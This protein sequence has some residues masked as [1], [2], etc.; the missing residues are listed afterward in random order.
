MEGKDRTLWDL[1]RGQRLRY[2]AAIA[3]MGLG[4]LCVFQVPLVGRRVLDAIAGGA[5][6]DARMLWTA[7]A[8]VVG[9]TAV[10]SALQYLRGRWAAI[11]SEAIVRRLRDR[12]YGHLER[13]PCAYHD[14]AD[15]G[16]LVQRCSS[17]VETV[18]VFLAA[19][20]VEVGRATLLLLIV[21]PI[22]LSLDVRL[23]LVG[24]GLFPVIIAFAVVF[25]RRIKALFLKVDEAEG[26]M[27]A[28]L[29]ENLTGVRVV[30]AF[31][32]RDFECAKFA[33]RNA[34]HRDLN[35][36]LINMLGNYWALS[37][38]LCMGQ[39]GIVLIVG[40]WWTAHG[41]LS[42]GTLFAFFSY[43]QM[44]VWPARHLGRVLADAGKAIVAL[45]RIGE[46]LAAPEESG[47]AA[48][49]QPAAL[50]GAIDV[51]GL[52]FSFDGQEPVVRDLS[53][54]VRAGDTVALLGR[55]GA[56]KSTLIQLLLRLYD[57]EQG[58][59]RLDGH[60]LNGLDR[61]F[62]R[63]QVGVVLQEPFLYSKTV[64]GNVRVGR[65]RAT[66]DELVAST[67]DA[68][69]HTSIEQFEQGYETLVGE[70]G[71]TLSGGQR[72]RVAI[73]RALLK[74]P[75]I[76]VLDD[77]LSAVDTGTETQILEALRRRRRKRTTIVIAHRLSSVVHADKIVVLEHGRIVQTGMHRELI[78]CAGPYRRL[79]RIQGA[80]E[81]ELDEDLLVEGQP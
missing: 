64:A 19:Q 5:D 61:R 27:T 39:V 44:V 15:T 40:G 53:L 24:I 71:V 63:S 34:E 70:R 60:E 54:R 2:F 57:Y 29:Q 16:D 81:D 41:Q 35:H 17:D 67:T 45:G 42:V 13:L 48:T 43:V 80:L 73:A 56:G 46:I 23:T 7:A 77:A 55:P 38:V 20:V 68:C 69:I 52:T 21:I 11:A 4:F 22:L 6:V 47:Q 76:L 10:G 75:P 72:Q 37:D 51:E 50:S 18:R 3:A 33:K 14:H 1:T 65:S 12:L 58:S 66:H 74:D 26:R 49:P 59:I 79:W 25:F 8:W 62:V 78:A 36:R 32:R 30:R 31:A 28:V 9:F